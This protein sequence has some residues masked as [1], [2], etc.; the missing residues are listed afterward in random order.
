MTLRANEGGRG[1]TSGAA[2]DVC[3]LSEDDGLRTEDDP[4]IDRRGVFFTVDGVGKAIDVLGLPR[5]VAKVVPADELVDAA[6]EAVFSGDVDLFGDA[7]AVVGALTEREGV[8]A[9]G[10]SDF[11]CWARSLAVM[12]TYFEALDPTV[13][14]ASAACEADG[15]CGFAAAALSSTTSL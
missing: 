4:P 6:N 14:R 2:E 10:A 3:V 7:V 1:G 12:P 8:V 15:C 9:V 11:R 5:G 13:I